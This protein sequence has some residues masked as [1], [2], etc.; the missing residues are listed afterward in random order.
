MVLS[1]TPIS[2]SAQESPLSGSEEIIDSGLPPGTEMDVDADTDADM[3]SDGDIGAKEPP[4]PPVRPADAGV[5]RS[6][7]APM[8][9]IDPT[10]AFVVDE[11]SYATLP[12]AIAAV[13]SEGGTIVLQKDASPSVTDTL[14]IEDK[15]ITF[16][17]TKGNLSI[18]KSAGLA[19]KVKNCT[20]SVTGDG[21][22]D[23]AGGVGIHADNGTIT[24]RDVTGNQGDGAY[25]FNG[26]N[27]T[28]EGEAKS[29][30]SSGKAVHAQLD[31]H[32]EAN[33]AIATGSGSYGALADGGTV[34]ITQDAQGLRG[35]VRAINSGTITVG[36]NAV[37]NSAGDYGAGAEAESGGTITVQGSVTGY[38]T[39]VLATGE[40]S[41]VTVTMNVITT[42]NYSV[43]VSPQDGGYIEVGQDVTSTAEYSTGA[44]ATDGGRAHIKGHVSVTLNG[45]QAANLA[46]Q[47]TVDKNITV[48][49][50]N[51][52]AIQVDEN[53]TVTVGG[54]VTAESSGSKGFYVTGGTA[55]V[56]GDVSAGE[57]GVVVTFE[58]GDV[59][60]GGTL[61][62]LNPTPYIEFSG[63]PKDI[64]DHTVD[65]ETGYRIYTNGTSTV[66][67][68]NSLPAI[69]AHTVTAAAETSTP[70]AG[71]AN[72]ITLTVKDSSGNT[73]TAFT[74][75][76]DVTLSGAQ[77]VSHGYCGL[78]CDIIIP[79]DGSLT[80]SVIFTNGVATPAL[81]LF[82]AGAQAISFSVAGVTNPLDSVNFTV[83]PHAPSSMK[84]TQNITAP[85]VN[86][87]Q[88]AQ[89]PKLELKDLY[90]NLCTNDST[91]QVTAAKN[92]DGNW[93]LTG[94]ATVTAVNG[95]ATF[96]DLGAANTAQV[97]GA[98][99]IFSA[100][101]GENTL[102]SAE[103]T[104]PAS[105]ETDGIFELDGERYPTL[106]ETLEK[107]PDGGAGSIKLHDNAVAT[108]PIVVDGIDVTFLL[109]IYTLNLDTSGTED[110]TALTV[111][112]GGKADFDG[113]GKFNVIGSFSAV[114][115]EGTGS[116][117][118]VSRAETTGDSAYTVH[119][120][121][122][123][124][125]TV[126]GDVL[127]RGD[128]GYALWAVLGGQVTVEGAVQCFGENT[129]GVY[130]N[131]AGSKATVER[132]VVAAA[133]NSKG[134]NA[135]NG[136]AAEITGDVTAGK[137]GVT[138]SGSGAP[139]S[140]VTVYGNVTVNSTESEIIGVSA[141]GDTNILITG[142]VTAKG[143]GSTGAYANGSSIVIGGKVTSDGIG[144]EA[145]NSGSI[146]IDGMLAAEGAY[147]KV[148]GVP[149]AID[150]YDTESTDPNYWV[151]KNG[152]SIVSIKKV[153]ITVLPTVVTGAVTGVTDS[154]AVLSGSISSDGGGEISEYG[155]A[156][157]SDEN[158]TILSDHKAAGTG[159]SSGFTASL[160]GLIANTNYHVRAY[161]KNSA[162]TSYG[163][164]VSFTTFPATPISYTV[165]VQNDGHGTGSASPSSAEA[166]TEVILTA[167]PSN[168]YVF[169]EWQII[170]GGVT[171]S[172]NKFTMPA[173][174]VIVKA[175]FEET[176]VQ[177]YMVTV[178]GSH[179]STTGAGSY[180]KDVTVNI[181]AGN[182]SGY[183]FTGWTSSDVMITD[184]GNKNTSFIMP[185]KNVIVSANWRYNGGSGGGSDS[186]DND[187]NPSVTPPAAS[188]WLE[189]S[190]TSAPIA[191]AEEKGLGYILTRRN[192]QY[193]VRKT[194]WL[195]LAGYQYWHDTMD[196][197]AVQVRVYIKN[198]TAITSDLL[199]SG[200][201]KGSEVDRVKALFEKYFSNKV[202]AIH[203][204][205]TGTWGQAAEIAAR[206]D[207]TGMDVTKLYLYSYNKATNT[208]RRIEK[209]AYWVDTNGYLHFTTALAGDIIISEGPLARLE[210]GGAK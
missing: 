89:Q 158:P 41:T 65:P 150:E 148:A 33:N 157:G 32:V 38:S 73:D 74:G 180:T 40:N 43:G 184:A 83:V 52:T 69:P 2:A 50:A 200:Y 122:G 22:L 198:P 135:K 130:S 207:L 153:A 209:S 37:C 39:G 15:D 45:V 152:N 82:K 63:V 7:V 143:V 91:T 193:G 185:E 206:V 17:L 68:G 48:S 71:V 120:S 111:Q 183:T 141:G 103:V 56:A 119:S 145:T 142:N 94:T 134:V 196:A 168:G 9:V 123:G 204:D 64:E 16:D 80:T 203:M 92:D 97:T 46:S 96:T 129:L 174:D 208:Y 8:G 160:T 35:G 132:G 137:T 166:G 29:N 12:D 99:L 178:N 172:G 10:H 101:A 93:T 131:G 181:Y 42:N 192:N 115:V 11:T 194:T 113:S 163:A 36:G 100:N 51:A 53:G 85:A 108:T 210:N 98:Q 186:S 197:S 138:T 25:A 84:L 169:K 187:S 75:P 140:E 175:I 34:E 144:A 87:G 79:A 173:G 6:G 55:A 165:T 118:T 149:K 86:G 177:T 125:I 114:R 88:F 136:G 155:F 154:T 102:L 90:A 189:Q 1:L 61:T 30:G 14:L 139:P 161:A 58:G 28:V 156:W 128:G 18:F 176:L 5:A 27:I 116:E 171:V 20:V 202:R 13:P 195:S 151:Y 62:V 121:S 170:S 167:T 117:A 49:G 54:N 107:I 60:I 199:V 31:G 179:A 126:K 133:S 191:D 44:N 190:G 21:Y 127:C 66:R 201:V 59:T 3:E 47:V 124:L 164:D 159:G 147:V 19:L 109:G 4:S 104:L 81:K 57:K 72:T 76:H 23:V 188:E 95:I 182:R 112:N 106:G 70:V 162:G 24:V 78:F 67:V 146:R 205:Q 105:E 26:G 77:A 110:S